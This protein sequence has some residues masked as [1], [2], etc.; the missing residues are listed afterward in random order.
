MDTLILIGVVSAWS[1]SLIGAVVRE[2]R[3]ESRLRYRLIL[4]KDDAPRSVVVSVD[5]QRPWIGRPYRP[6]RKTPSGLD[7]FAALSA[8]TLRGRILTGIGLRGRA[9]RFDFSGGVVWVAEMR[10]H[11]ANLV[12]LDDEERVTVAARSTKTSKKRIEPGKSYAVDELPAGTLDLSEATARQIDDAVAIQI[13]SGEAPARAI[14]RTL[15]GLGSNSVRL[16]LDAAEGATSVGET[17]LAR[18][19]AIESGAL[20]PVIECSEPPVEAAEHGRFDGET[21]RLLPW[22]ADG[23][24]VDGFERYSATDA[25]ATAGLFFDCLD[26]SISTV[27]RGSTLRSIVDAEIRRHRQAESRSRADLARFADPERFK[28]WAEALLA[29]LSTARRAGGQVLV[30]DPYDGDGAVLAVP[31]RPGK[32]LNAL[33]DEYFQQHRR[34]KRGLQRAMERAES[35]AVE[36]RRLEKV[37]SGWPD[38]LS[39][40]SLD[41]VEGQLRDAGL[42]VGLDNSTKRRTATPER[43]RLEGV[44]LFTAASGASILVGKTAKDNQRLTF[45]LAGP[46]DFWLHALGVPGAHVILRND[47]R[48]KAPDR[49]DLIQAA[50]VAAWFSEAKS[51]PVTDVQ[52]TRRKYVRKLRGGPPG[53]VTVKRSE[54][55]RVR[56]S[57]L[58]NSG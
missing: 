11:Q 35:V 6:R 16:L 20:E 1:R 41:R 24:S 21:A 10:P 25:A 2:V 17:V 47:E 18:L 33:A 19:A 22:T 57:A 12:L 30:T 42:P 28:K 14:S 5:P 48:K 49:R 29:G 39:S 50:G 9:V 23:P 54:T 3:M 52:W 51:Q 43:P 8:K 56:P 26:L 4:E 55:V 38:V 7:P 34:A 37:R 32:S 44:R 27:R 36:M 15:V 53:T 13:Q 46:E 45:K 40:A 58:E 31:D